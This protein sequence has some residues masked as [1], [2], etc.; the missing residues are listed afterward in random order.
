MVVNSCC[1]A[2]ASYLDYDGRRGLKV[3]LEQNE[4]SRPRFYL[5]AIA[6]DDVDE[7]PFVRFLQG[8]EE[9]KDLGLSGLSLKQKVVIRYCPH[10]GTELASLI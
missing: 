3:V 2:F 4:G 6:I 7:L 5:S 1:P 10:C 9:V 8:N